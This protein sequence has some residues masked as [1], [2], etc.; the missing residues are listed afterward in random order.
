[1]GLA[2]ISLAHDNIFL[3]LAL[4]LLSE[5]VLKNNQLLVQFKNMFAIT[6]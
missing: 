1:V 4:L 5:I 6:F 2:Q 3:A